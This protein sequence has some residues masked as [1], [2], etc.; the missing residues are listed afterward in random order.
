MFWTDGCLQDVVAYERWLHLEFQPYRALF[1]TLYPTIKLQ[2]SIFTL[3]TV[4]VV[5][6]Y[7]HAVP[8]FYQVAI[9]FKEGKKQ[10]ALYDVTYLHLEVKS[11]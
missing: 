2:S 8:T 9:G 6:S 10:Y 5:C 11:Q 7:M 1:E 4:L 3:D